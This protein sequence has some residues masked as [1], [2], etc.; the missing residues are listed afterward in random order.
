MKGGGADRVA[1]YKRR[2]RALISAPKKTRKKRENT[3]NNGNG[4]EPGGEMFF[5]RKGISSFVLLGRQNIGQLT[6]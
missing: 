5:D 3:K 4:S 2:R 1:G 6:I